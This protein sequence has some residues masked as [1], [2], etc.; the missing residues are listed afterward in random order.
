MAHPANKVFNRY[1]R[2]PIW[3]SLIFLAVSTFLSFLHWISKLCNIHTFQSY[4]RW[5]HAGSNYNHL[6]GSTGMQGVCKCVTTEHWFDTDLL[7]LIHILQPFYAC[8]FLFV[9]SEAHQN[10]HDAFAVLP[11]YTSLYYFL[12]TYWSQSSSVLLFCWYQFFLS[13][14]YLQILVALLKLRK[15]ES[16]FP[17]M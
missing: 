1:G 7:L 5:Q 12:D 10:L 11:G 14:I 4:C 8:F 9:E 15:K 13:L 16:E 3:G 17:N 6:L 2:S